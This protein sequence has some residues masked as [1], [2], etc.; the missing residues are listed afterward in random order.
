MTDFVR[1]FGDEIS[2]GG[3]SAKGSVYNNTMYF[4]DIS[5]TTTG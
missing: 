1:Y 3:Y 2:Y 5:N 4:Y